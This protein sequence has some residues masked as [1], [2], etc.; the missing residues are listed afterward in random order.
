MHHHHL[1]AM[2][3]TIQD[4]RRRSPSS[5]RSLAAASLAGR[6]DSAQAAP[7][8]LPPP[9]LAPATAAR[10]AS[11]SVAWGLLGVSPWDGDVLGWSL[12]VKEGAAWAGL[13]DGNRSW[14]PRAEDGGALPCPRQGRP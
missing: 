5:C 3:C 10:S 4:R 12:G 1:R 9:C 6:V 8:L 2:F 14:A 7:S 11:S 13:E